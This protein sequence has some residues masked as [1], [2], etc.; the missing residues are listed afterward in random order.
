[1]KAKGIE[2]QANC[3]LQISDTYRA[4]AMEQIK[5]NDQPCAK[6]YANQSISFKKKALMLRQLSVQVEVA[7]TQLLSAGMF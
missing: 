1:M 4:K 6:M 3:F 5:L 7:S 2:K